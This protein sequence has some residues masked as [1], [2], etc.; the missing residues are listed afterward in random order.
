M[1]A[2]PADDAIP[3]RPELA[4][5]AVYVWRLA[6][7]RTPDEVAQLRL[8]LSEDER[9]RADRYR[10]ERDRARFVVG[11]GLLRR[12]LALYL[13][14]APERLR[15]AYGPHGKPE[16]AGSRGV[17]LRF[18]LAHSDELALLA[19]ALGREVGIDVERVRTDLDVEPLAARYFSPRE[20]AILAALPAE[21][22]SRA[23]YTCWTRKEA[24]VKAL[25]EGLGLSLDSFSVAL[26]PGAAPALLAVAGRPGEADRWTLREVE[27]SDGFAAALAVEGRLAHVCY[28]AAI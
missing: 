1:A 12:V 22:R 26:A 18:N 24:Y 3:K 10:I 7:D 4:H 16:L 6:L 28:T 11:R 9:E 20:N 2:Y 15:F 25:G 8:V 13:E 17:N 14:Q 5:D 19:I 27:A 23:F 21:Q